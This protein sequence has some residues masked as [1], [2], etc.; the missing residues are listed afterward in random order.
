[1]VNTI[2]ISSSV[3]VGCKYNWLVVVVVAGVL[4]VNNK[5]WVCWLHPAELYLIMSAEVIVCD[6]LSRRGRLVLVR[7]SSGLASNCGI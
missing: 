4:W 5:S 7:G 2:V 3:T 6:G 1:M